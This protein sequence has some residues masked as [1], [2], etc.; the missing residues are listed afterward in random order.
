MIS[1]SEYPAVGR[2]DLQLYG[3]LYPCDMATTTDMKVTPLALNRSPEDYLEQ[4]RLRLESGYYLQK[5]VSAYVARCLMA[6]LLPPSDDREPKGSA[7]DR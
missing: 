2:F 6:D 3:L 7:S 5:D 4:A 1:T